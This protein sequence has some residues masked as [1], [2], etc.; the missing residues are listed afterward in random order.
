M[1]FSVLL[2]CD[3]TLLVIPV[4]WCANLN[5]VQIMNYGASRNVKRRVFFS[6]DFTK[7]P[8]FNLPL[9]IQFDEFN[10]SCYLAYFKKA[11]DTFDQAYGY[12][13]TQRR[14][15]PAVYNIRWL[16]ESVPN[17]LPVIP[18]D[19][20]AEIKAQIA[21]LRAA[22]RLVNSMVPTQDLTD[23]EMIEFNELIELNDDEDAGSYVPVNQH[24]ITMIF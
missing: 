23:G 18:V 15:Y 21:P 10:D 12:N 16:Q 17:M 2:H 6:S 19:T 5:M 1:Y 4:A 24:V 9:G 22:L 13:N 20:K 7:Q 14:N 8:N 11:F 3:K